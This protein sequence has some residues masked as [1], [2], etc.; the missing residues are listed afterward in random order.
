MFT[1]ERLNLHSR[2]GRIG[3]IGGIGRIGRIGR[4]G[5]KYL[6]N[7]YRIPYIAY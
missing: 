4:I 3:E 6:T 5:G 7:M 1:L 2:I